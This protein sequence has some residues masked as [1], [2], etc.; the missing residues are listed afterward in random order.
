MLYWQADQPI[1]LFALLSLC[2]VIGWYIVA[3]CTLTLL[4]PRT[5]HVYTLEHADGVCKPWLFV[6]HTYSHLVGLM[7]LPTV[8]GGV[9]SLYI[10]INAPL[11]F[12]DIALGVT[13]MC[14]PQALVVAFLILVSCASTAPP[15]AYRVNSIGTISTTLFQGFLVPRPAQPVFLGWI[16]FINPIFWTYA[17][18]VQSVLANKVLPCDHLSPLSCQSKHFNTFISQFGLDAINIYAALFFLFSCTALCLLLALAVLHDVS[19]GK[20]KEKLQGERPN[21]E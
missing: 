20:V 13:F 14:M 21:G 3:P 2:S 1:Q 8:V 4:L 17:A 19:W 7:I 6:L 16:P 18:L 11:S 5:R 10:A 9:C 12:R 15:H